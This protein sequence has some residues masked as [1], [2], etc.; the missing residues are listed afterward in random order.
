[1]A[2]FRKN[3]YVYSFI[4]NHSSL[5]DENTIFAIYSI[6]LEYVTNKYLVK[7]YGSLNIFK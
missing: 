7:Y 4:D 3:M 1:M 6:Y 5:I 2:Q